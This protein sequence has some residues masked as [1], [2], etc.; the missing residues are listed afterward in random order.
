M[1]RRSSSGVRSC[2]VPLC[3]VACAVAAPSNVRAED[4]L[5]VTADAESAES[6]LTVGAEVDV[7]S[8]SI[9]R[10]VALNAGPAIQP[11]AWV[12]TSGASITAWTSFDPAL[13][14]ETRHRPTDFNGVLAYDGTLG[15]VTLAPSATWITF[16]GLAGA[17]QSVELALDTNVE[18]GPV[19][20]CVSNVADVLAFT[21]A[22]Y[23]RAGV[24]T[25]HTFSTRWVAT[26][27]AVAGG[28]NRR[29]HEA[30]AGVSTTGLGH[31]E[32][33]VGL[34]VPAP[35]GAY[36]RLHATCS[37]LVHPALIAAATEPTLVVGGLAVGAEM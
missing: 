18:A 16:P 35:G 8:R 12:A 3:G 7:P 13:A 17:P 27:D 6:A 32:A 25:E 36:L 14:S 22:W 2:I 26:A 5:T 9:S 31:A 30:N 28:G 34:T 19:S 15:P 33:N 37:R 1:A 4:A 24:C 20:L 21:G 10:G 11:S 23:V 29:Y